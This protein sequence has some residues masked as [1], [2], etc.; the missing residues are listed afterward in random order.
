MSRPLEMRSAVA[1][2]SRILAVALAGLLVAC[3]RLPPEE[4]PSGSPRAGRV[5][6][7][8]ATALVRARIF[9]DKP[10]MNESMEAP[11]MELTTDQMW[12]RL[13]VQL[14]KVTDGVA[15]CTSYLI[16]GRR[17][18]LLCGGF[19]G[20]G[21]QSACVTDLD[22]DGVPELTYTYS[23]GSLIHSSLVGVCRVDGDRL[24]NEAATLA[25]MG[26]LFVRKETDSR[27]IVEIGRYG[28]EFSSWTPEAQ[29]GVIEL[30][31]E[32]AQL[33]PRIELAPLSEEHAELIGPR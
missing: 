3:C 6:L 15:E 22:G 31:R 16:W 23:S 14:Y 21:I 1:S 7:E 12:R 27:V 2:A 11:L 28:W 5:G 25:F 29:L 32:G 18:H 4:E 10:T 30:K 33:V 13:G 9:E 20:H 24:L 17:A 26:D 19:G 8:E